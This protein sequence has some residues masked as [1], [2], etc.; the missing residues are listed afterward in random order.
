MKA[1]SAGVMGAKVPV[2]PSLQLWLVFIIEFIEYVLLITYLVL[3]PW[4]II[5]F[6]AAWFTM[7]E[8]DVRFV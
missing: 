8:P 2:P 1:F 7:V 6:S 3:L 5:Q 4:N